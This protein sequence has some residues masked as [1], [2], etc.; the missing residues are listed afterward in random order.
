MRDPVPAPRASDHDREA[1][2]EHLREAVGDGRLDLVEFED[3]MT[4]AYAART[5][6]ELDPLL[7]DLPP[8]LPSVPVAPVVLRGFMSSHQRSRRWAVPAHLQVSMTMSSVR[9][10]LTEAV[11]PPVVDLDVAL[12]MSSIDLLVPVGVQID[13]DGVRDLMSNVSNRVHHDGRGPVVRLRGRAVMSSVRI[14]H[15]GTISQ[16]WRSLNR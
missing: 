7:A 4:A 14:K 5:R 10:D 9:L 13:A 8:T 3:R 1:V 2:V 11:L 16:L 6:P 12:V 15:P